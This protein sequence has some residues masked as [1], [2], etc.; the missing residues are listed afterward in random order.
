MI[1]FFLSK[2]KWQ[3]ENNNDAHPQLQFQQNISELDLQ[4]VAS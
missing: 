2:L 1:Y 3:I 4:L